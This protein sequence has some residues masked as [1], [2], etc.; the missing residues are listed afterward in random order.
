MKK[1]RQ[2]GERATGWPKRLG[3]LRHNTAIE[4]YRANHRPTPGTITRSPDERVS[5]GGLQDTAE[6]GRLWAVTGAYI[7]RLKLRFRAISSRWQWSWPVRAGFPGAFPNAMEITHL[8]QVG[9]CTQKDRTLKCNL[10]QFLQV[11]VRGRLHG[12]GG[13]D[14]TAVS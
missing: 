2:A 4:P 11:K 8:M 6:I 9:G 1:T 5:V 7:R 14:R 10:Q 3:R 12:G 13:K